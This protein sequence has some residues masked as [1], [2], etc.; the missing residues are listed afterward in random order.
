MHKAHEL[1]ST[2]PFS[3]FSHLASQERCEIDFEFLGFTEQYKMLSS[4]IPK[5][6][7]IVDLGCYMAFQSHYFKDHKQ[8]I[9]VDV[10]E[11]ERYKT[12]NSTHFTM[13]IQEF[14][15]SVLPT[16]NLDLGKTFAIC[17]YVPDTEAT[18]FARKTFSNIFCFY[19]DL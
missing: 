9:G 3:Q 13:S 16:L 15:I 8:Y 19:P 18:S 5:D 2:I 14:I 1:L 17:N 10:C 4:V 11:L 12:S 7:T 6:F